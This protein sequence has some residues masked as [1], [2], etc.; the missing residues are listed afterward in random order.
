[1]VATDGGR[2]ETTPLNVGLER[3]LYL[4]VRPS[5]EKSD[6]IERV[7]LGTIEDNALPILQDIEGRWPLQ[8]REKLDLATYL[9][10][11]FVRGPRW[12]EW[13]D[14]FAKSNYREYLDRGEFRGLSQEHGVS[15][16]EVY[17]AHVDAHT[18]P[19]QKLLAML[20]LG[21]KVGT[22]FG[23]MTWALLKFSRP[24]LALADHPLSLW[25]LQP[26]GRLTARFE[27]AKT[28]L[29][30]LLEVRVPLAPDI[31]L[32]MAWA[33]RP[34]IDDPY[35]CASHHARNMNA[36]SLAEAE[37]HWLYRPP[38][39]APR[40]GPG[41]WMPLSTELIPGYSVAAAVES[42]SRAAV[43][44]ELN[45]RLGDESREVK[46]RFIESRAA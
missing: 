24:C 9:G 26:G 4:R 16:T 18:D 46:I 21:A 43:S 40:S 7:S 33:D 37:R 39:S 20:Q 28:G 29:L 10:V 25:P 30:N 6:D 35:R 13:H 42:P 44:E 3:D 2:F 5:G 17:E 34:D 27:L 19:T 8:A 41:P 38:G 11:L 15:E 12:F 32:L 45:G 23:F 1:M 14:A 36:F 31:A 22:T